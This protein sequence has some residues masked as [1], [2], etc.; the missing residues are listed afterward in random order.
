MWMVIDNNGS[1]FKYNY[2]QEKTIL[3]SNLNTEHNFFSNKK[4]FLFQPSLNYWHFIYDFIG[5]ILLIGKDEGY[6]DTEF[7]IVIDNTL[8]PKTKILP[9]LTDFFKT[10]GLNNYHI[11]GNDQIF[12]INSFYNV[13]SQLP[14]STPVHNLIYEAFL[15]SY[16]TNI[17]APQK[18]VYVSRSKAGVNKIDKEIKLENFFKE[19]GFE[20]LSREFFDKNTLIDDIKY[21]RDVK[22]LAGLSGAGL[23]NAIFMQPGNMVIE[24]AIPQITH[25]AEEED[26]YPNKRVIAR[27]LFHPA[28]SFIKDHTHIQ[29]A[30]NDNNPDN[31]INKINKLG[32]LE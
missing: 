27:H 24:I 1:Q 5:Q 6:E 10:I 7:I 20:I 21:F 25:V 18:M 8:T 14:P 9:F 15:K 19:K 32:I 23:T 11:L 16:P 13:H 31:V 30:V 28:S 17:E 3:N 4:K 22:I 12:S 26:L 2:L 29:I